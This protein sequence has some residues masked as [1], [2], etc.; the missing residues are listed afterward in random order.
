MPAGSAMAA[1]SHIV[2]MITQTVIL[3]LAWIAPKGEAAMHRCESAKEA[4]NRGCQL[5]SVHGSWSWLP[6]MACVLA[7]TSIALQ[8]E[9]ANIE[10][11]NYRSWDYHRPSRSVL[12]SITGL[13]VETAA[14]W[15]SELGAA[16]TLL[17]D[18]VVEL[19]AQGHHSVWE[20]VRHAA[21]GTRDLHDLVGLHI[22]RFSSTS[23]P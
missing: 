11:I 20:T 5:L 8:S 19:A 13:S 17:D 22:A 6:K 9:L 16:A 2:G 1:N 3:L 21:D 10:N 14:L 4:L 12:D 23:E 18:F 7:R 15:R